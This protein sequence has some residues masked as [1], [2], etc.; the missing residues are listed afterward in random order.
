MLT[1]LAER[2]ECYNETSIIMKYTFG[3]AWNAMDWRITWDIIK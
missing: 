1:L 3:V 2:N